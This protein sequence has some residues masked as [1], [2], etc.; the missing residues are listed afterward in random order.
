MPAEKKRYKGVFNWYNEVHTLYTYAKDEKKA[1][2]NFVTRLAKLLEVPG[3]R[4]YYYFL[5]KIFIKIL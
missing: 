5:T 4:V 2:N 3:S 1:F